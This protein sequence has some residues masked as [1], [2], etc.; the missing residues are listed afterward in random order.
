MYDL[1]PDERR[2]LFWTALRAFA[3]ETG[4]ISVIIGVWILLSALRRR[5]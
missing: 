3:I 5:F 1:D 4:L 2:S